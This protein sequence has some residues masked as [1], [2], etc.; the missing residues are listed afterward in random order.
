[1]PCAGL[2]LQKGRQARAAACARECS[3]R[4]QVHLPH[5]NIVMCG[6]LSERCRFGQYV[7]GELHFKGE[8]GADKSNAEAFA[9]Y[10]AAARQQHD[11]A[12]FELGY[13]HRF[14]VLKKSAE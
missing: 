1:M 7:L 11:G 6:S 14:P 13:L 8:G 5:T 12:L 10:S 9:C 4:Q 2:R 3:G